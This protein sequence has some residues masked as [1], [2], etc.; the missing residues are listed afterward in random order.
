MGVES[1]VPAALLSMM[2]DLLISCATARSGSLL[3][4]M[5]GAR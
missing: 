1:E 4:L 5:G 2:M 3:A